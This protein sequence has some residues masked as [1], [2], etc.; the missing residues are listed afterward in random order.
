MIEFASVYA[1]EYNVYSSG[2]AS[3]DNGKFLTHIG[4]E[5]VRRKTL[6][7]ANSG[8]NVPPPAPVSGCAVS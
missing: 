4:E 3:F 1:E 8:N 6:A 5:Q 2:S 7:D